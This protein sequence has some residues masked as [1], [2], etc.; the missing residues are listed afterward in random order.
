MTGSAIY[1]YVVPSSSGGGYT[2]QID[3][4]TVQQLSSHVDQNA[5]QD[6]CIA[7]QQFSHERMDDVAHKIVVK[8]AAGNLEF[9]G[10]TYVQIRFTI[11]LW[12]YR[13]L[14]SS[15]VPDFRT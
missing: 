15:V 14:F 10:F 2:V 6:K 3:G 11:P 13:S 1:L 8:N 5:A 9:N 12:F 7:T 4:E